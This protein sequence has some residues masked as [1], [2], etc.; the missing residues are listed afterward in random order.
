[1]DFR[2]LSITSTTVQQRKGMR[3]EAI[4]LYDKPCTFTLYVLNL[5]DAGTSSPPKPTSTTVQQRSGTF[6]HL[7]DPRAIPASTSGVALFGLMY[8]S[9]LTCLELRQPVRTVLTKSD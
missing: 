6:F 5:V 2:P 7:P 1:M 9:V 3:R 8:G 4:V